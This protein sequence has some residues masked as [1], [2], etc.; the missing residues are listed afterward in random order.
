MSDGAPAFRVRTAAVLDLHGDIDVRWGDY[1]LTGQYLNTGL[2]DAAAEQR[3]EQ[4]FVVLDALP[5]HHRPPPSV[6]QRSMH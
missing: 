2:G 1:R 6:R 4:L 5:K 3:A